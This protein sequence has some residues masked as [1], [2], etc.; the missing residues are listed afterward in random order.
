MLFLLLIKIIHQYLWNDTLKKS[1]VYYITD[2]NK[3]N[4]KNNCR[5]LYEKHLEGNKIRI[6][7][8]FWWITHLLVWKNKDRLECI[9]WR[10]HTGLLG[11]RKRWKFHG[12]G[13][14]SGRGTISLLCR[15]VKFILFVPSCH[16][17]NS[18]YHN[19]IFQNKSV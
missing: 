8:H 13:I 12:L 19:P 15:D 6:C 1:N 17:Y 5:K 7:G 11:I 9:M 16:S 10:N 18:K 3:K 2:I 4:R 14:I